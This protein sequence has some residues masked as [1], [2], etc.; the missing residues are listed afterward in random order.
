MSFLAVL[1]FPCVF[2]IYMFFFP[3]REGKFSSFVMGIISG[4]FALPVCIML[5]ITA[6]SSVEFWVISFSFFFSYFFLPLVIGLSFYFI[7]TFSSFS[8]GKIPSAMFGIFSVFIFYML[9]EFVNIPDVSPLIILSLVYTSLIFFTDIVFS[10]LLK[11][12]AIMNMF[13]VTIAGCLCSL[14]ASF[15]LCMFFSLWF[16]NYSSWFYFLLPLGIAFLSGLLLRLM[17]AAF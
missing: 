3:A 1:L 15:F 16:F 4:I 8:A 17:K 14:A 7:F 13:I 2:A 9:F 6:Y 12:M 11:A 10:I 5:K